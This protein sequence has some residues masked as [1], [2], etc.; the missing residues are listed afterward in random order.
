MSRH[1]AQEL[2]KW[3]HNTGEKHIHNFTNTHFEDHELQKPSR[4]VLES[5]KAQTQDAINKILGLKTAVAQKSLGNQVEDNSS[6][7]QFIRLTPN[8]QGKGHNS[9]ATQRIIRMQ[10]T[11]V[12]P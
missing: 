11:Q 9:G 1:V 4:G 2:A 7:V 8:Q 12:D 5:I 6:K 3:N 10:E